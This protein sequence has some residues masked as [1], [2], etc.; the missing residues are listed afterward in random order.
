MSARTERA[1]SL[2]H[3]YTP[4]AYC[5]TANFGVF[6]TDFGTG[7]SSASKTVLVYWSIMFHSLG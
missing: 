5:A 1:P 2:F 4:K 3:N 6:M 7:N